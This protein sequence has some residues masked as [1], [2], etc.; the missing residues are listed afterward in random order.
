MATPAT[1]M[2]PGGGGLAGPGEPVPVAFVGRTSTLE[3]QDPVA[4]LRRQVRASKAALPPGCF[5]AARYWDIE[6]GGLDPG[7]YP[8]S[9]GA[10]TQRRG[11][12]GRV[13]YHDLGRGTNQ[14]Q[15]VPRGVE[16]GESGPDDHH[17]VLLFIS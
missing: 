6:S 1:P 17:T 5:I 4:S 16:A 15:Q 12:V 14:A 8:A 2:A 13:D 9:C 11:Q 7:P 3:L 10:A